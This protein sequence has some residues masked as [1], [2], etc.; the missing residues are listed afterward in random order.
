MKA[1]SR[2]K[3]NLGKHH[4]KGSS[5][6]SVEGRKHFGNGEGRRNCVGFDLEGGE[7]GRQTILIRLSGAWRSG[8]AQLKGN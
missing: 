5:F 3:T 8:G 7:G 6:R 2:F 1:S 4:C